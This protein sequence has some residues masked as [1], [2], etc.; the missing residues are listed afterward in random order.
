MARMDKSMRE[1]LEQVAEVLEVPEVKPGDAFRA[2]PLWGSLTGFALAVMLEQRYGR[3]VAAG[4]FAHLET[5]ADL[6]AF[7]GVTA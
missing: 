2:V 3:P 7:A 5:V 6:A 4:D 1:F